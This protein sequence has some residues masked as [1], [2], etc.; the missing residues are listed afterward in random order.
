MLNEIRSARAIAL[1][2]ILALGIAACDQAGR[3]G[4]PLTGPQPAARFA[5]DLGHQP[6]WSSPVY[7]DL[8]PLLEEEKTRLSNEQELTK[9][10]LDSLKVIWDEFRAEDHD[11]YDS[12]F[13]MCQPLS[14]SAET[15]I[16]GPE[17]G[18][19]GIGPHKLQIPEGALSEYTVIT[20]EVPVSTQV[21]VK[22]SPHGLEFLTNAVLEINYK[23]CY[24]PEDFFYEMVYVDEDNNILERP[25]SW[26]LKSEGEVI[27]E[28]DHFSRYVIAYPN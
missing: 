4:S 11:K 15:K 6:G 1:A 27:G 12:P 25:Y 28:I 22:L 13:L 9:P 24:T 10:L 3:D 8:L 17:G 18:A 5:A 19:M 26:D 7:E 23:H 20:G 21:G 2:A 14:Y 16:I